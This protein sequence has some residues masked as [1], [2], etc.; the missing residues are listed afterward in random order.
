MRD[1]PSATHWNVEDGYQSNVNESKLY[2]H[3]V[4]GSTVHKGMILMPL[5]GDDNIFP[6]CSPVTAFIISL[7][8]PDEAVDI[9][10]NSI[11]IPPGQ[12][13]RISI[14]PK[15]TVASK[16]LRSYAPQV[17]G[18]YFLSERRLRFFKM[19]SQRKCKI[20]C[21]ANFTMNECGCVPFYMPS[22]SNLGI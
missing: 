16:G 9:H 15:V 4:F 18:C 8:M 5:I 14:K 1:N 6:P 10:K 19:Y 7:N 12:L 20:E 17:R 13:S 21:M 11:F 2:P 22:N 3:R